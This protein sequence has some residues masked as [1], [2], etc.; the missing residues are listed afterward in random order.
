M[1]RAAT[2]TGDA[3]F[4]G[5]AAAAGTVGGFFSSA[6]I[7]LRNTLIANNS[8]NECGGS[9]FLDQNNNLSFPD[10][11][12]TTC[13]AATLHGNPLLGA[14]ANNGGP[15][16]TMKLGAGSAAVNQVPLTLAN[17]QPTDQRQ[18]TR[19]KG[20]MCDVGAFELSAPSATTGASSA[21]TST[22]AKLA[23]TV[24]PGQVPTTYRF[25]F[26]KTTAYGSQTSTAS[27]GSGASSVAA[28]GTLTGLAPQT[29]YHYRLVATSPDGTATGA[30]RTF[31]TGQN[32]VATPPPGSSS[33]LGLR[34]LT[35]SARLSRTGVASIR[36]SAPPP[37]SPVAEARSSFTARVRVKVKSKK[38]TSA[39]TKRKT[40]R[41]GKANVSL[42]PGQTRTIR[43]KI[44][45]AGRRILRRSKRLRTTLTAAARDGTGGKAKTTTRRVTLRVAKRK[46]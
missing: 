2:G 14:L 33:F 39:Q 21:V 11:P 6:T 41:L 27:A 19:P 43:I 23:G 44:T 38:A 32:V 24:N 13:T 35:D 40:L 46:R 3:T 22:G 1:A 4:A 7:P 15:T 5:T 18:V 17:C 20:T 9:G 31:T 34:I 26:G 29:T 30:D 25:Q 42:R 36:S 8:G 10:A 28:A 12:M 37:R 45:R 16:F